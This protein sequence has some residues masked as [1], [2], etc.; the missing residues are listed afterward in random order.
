MDS[1]GIEWIGRDRK[2]SIGAERMGQDGSE[3][4]RQ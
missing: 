1:T 2:G 4:D 3:A